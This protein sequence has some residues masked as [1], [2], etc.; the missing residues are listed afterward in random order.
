MMKEENSIS[1]RVYFIIMR[2]ILYKEAH[3]GLFLYP[4]KT[5]R[6]VITELFSEMNSNKLGEFV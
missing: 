1:N 5:D 6:S 3:M 2:Y 4:Y